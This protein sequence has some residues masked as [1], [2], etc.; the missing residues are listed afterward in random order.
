MCLCTV[1]VGAPGTGKSTLID[2]LYPRA[3]YPMLN[4]GTTEQREAK[5]DESGHLCW[6]VSADHFFTQDD[7]SYNWS[8]EGL[9]R[10]HKTCF[11]KFQNAI[12]CGRDVVVDNTNLKH[13]M[14]REYLEAAEK[15]GY[16]IQVVVLEPTKGRKNIHGVAESHVAKMDSGRDLPG[17]TYTWS[18]EA[19]YRRISD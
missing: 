10:A 7:G 12:A 11:A 1:L 6:I 2:Q 18:S 3:Y 9:H 5:M 16:Q 14:R 19:G 4:R 15:A 13:R 8:P 17:G